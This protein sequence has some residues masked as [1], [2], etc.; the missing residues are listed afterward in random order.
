MDYVTTIRHQS[1]RF[2]DVLQGVDLAR[3]VPSCPDWTA[4]D[5]VWHLVEVQH[6]W[7]S[8]AGPP[9][10][11]PAEVAHLEPPE[12]A[13]LLDLFASRSARL[14]DALARHDPATPCYS[15][16]PEGGSIGWVRRRQAHEALIHRVDAELAAAVPVAGIDAALAADG[17]DE[18][19]RVMMHGVP[20]WG[21]FTADGVVIGL[22]ATDTGDAWTLAMGRFD[23]TSPDSGK[24]YE[25]LDAAMVQGGNA[26]EPAGT[27]SAAA[28]DLDR[29]LWGRG[30]PAA[31][32]GDATLRDRL[33]KLAA[34]VGG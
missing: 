29:W 4:A 20:P 22:E 7:G 28:W 30:E 19:L 14:V 11:D 26:A 23:G 25:G 32:A 18:M 31:V 10:T 15:W 13:E 34:D 8:I 9:L 2:H 5:L 17:V 6:F 21:T 1:Q 33:R 16:H 24:A 27:L 12:D 3:P